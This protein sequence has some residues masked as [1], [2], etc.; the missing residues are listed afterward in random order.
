M[1]KSAT[2]PCGQLKITVS[3][4]APQVHACA[5]LECQKRSGSSFTCTAFYPEDEVLSMEGTHKS[6]VRATH[7]GNPH[8]AFFC[9]DCGGSVFVRLGS[10]P[11]I[12]GINVGSF[13]DPDFAHPEKLYW[14]SRRHGWIG[15]PD[16]MATE[17]KQ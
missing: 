10:L 8:E 3:D 13:A 1:P 12:I 9:P 17:E 16:G 4:A 14:S 15:L 11:G 7:S 2:C 6:W 5:C